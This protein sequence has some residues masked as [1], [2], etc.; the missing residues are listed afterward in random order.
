MKI[1][2][3]IGCV[4]VYL[5]MWLVTGVFH[6]QHTSTYMYDA[7]GSCFVG[8]FWPITLPIIGMCTLIERIDWWLDHR[9]IR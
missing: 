8:L 5:I 3:I 6:A 2:I 4:I 1:L 9:V 7:L